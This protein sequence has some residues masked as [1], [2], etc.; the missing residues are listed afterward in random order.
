MADKIIHTNPIKE[1]LKTKLN[2]FVE[3]FS[4]FLLDAVLIVSYSCLEGLVKF[5]SEQWSTAPENVF[6]FNLM[7]ILF[8]ILPAIVVLAYVIIDI[9]KITKKIKDEYRSFVKK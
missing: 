7:K 8:A 3:I 4:T 2:W 9:I 5:I 1:T 6:V